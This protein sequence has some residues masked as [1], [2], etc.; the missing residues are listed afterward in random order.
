MI[1]LTG[2][3]INRVK[4]KSHY[5]LEIQGLQRNGQYRRCKKISNYKSKDEFEYD[6][7]KSRKVV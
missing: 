5:G 7:Y 4:R 2:V 3:T 1:M 6:C